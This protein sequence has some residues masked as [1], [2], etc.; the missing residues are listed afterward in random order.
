MT[1][2][3][4]KQIMFQKPT[5]N[6]TFDSKGFI[7]KIESGY[8]A[9]AQSKQNIKKA[10]SPSKLVYG[11]GRCP[12]YWYL[13]F[14]GGLFEDFSDAYSVA[15]MQSGTMSHKRILDGALKLSGMAIDVEFNV[16]TDD[17]LVFGYCDGLVNWNG[18][19]YVL[20]LKTCKNESFEY[21]K[22][23]MKPR[24]YNVEQLLMYMKILN[25]GKGIVL[26]ENKN[27]HELLP[28]VITANEHY[29]K[30]VDNL[31]TWMREV[32]S[33]SEAEQLPI[34]PYRSNA[35]VCKTCVLSS[36]CLKAGAGVIK[37]EP[38]EELSEDM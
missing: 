1:K 22:N 33:A 15:N 35:K 19:D 34:K 10:F 25:K 28:L 11:E 27:T 18:E 6:D 9:Q 38:L 24:A 7:E 3:L 14:K 31:F 23:K 8:L 26:Y 16:K 32:K 5:D 21:I 37:I 4:I 20:E 13:A 30:W 36:E 12:R 2:N 17:G 29:K